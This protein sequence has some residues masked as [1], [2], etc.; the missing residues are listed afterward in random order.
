MK[1]GI[2]VDFNEGVGN[3]VGNIICCCV[4]WSEGADVDRISLGVY[5]NVDI[6][7]GAMVASEGLE[8]GS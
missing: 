8:E 2:S 3:G 1:V 6:S 7:E 4:G 5:V